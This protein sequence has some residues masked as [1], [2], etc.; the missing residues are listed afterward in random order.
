MSPPPL[1]I[2]AGEV[3]DPRTRRR[4]FGQAPTLSWAILVSGILLFGLPYAVLTSILRELG[5]PG[6]GF[7]MQRFTGILM[8]RLLVVIVFTGPFVGALIWY[9]QNRKPRSE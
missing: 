9:E 5:E 4:M 2:V 8:T 6:A 7:D 1:P 3:S